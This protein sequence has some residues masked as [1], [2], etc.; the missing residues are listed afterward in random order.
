MTR[1]GVPASS[2]QRLVV[3][4]CNYFEDQDVRLMKRLDGRAVAQVTMHAEPGTVWRSGTRRVCRLGTIVE[5]SMVV[6]W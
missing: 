6:Y 3:L 5:R 2:A 1:S 4:A